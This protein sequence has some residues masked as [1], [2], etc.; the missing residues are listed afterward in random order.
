M[1]GVYSTF[2]VMDAIENASSRVM[3]IRMERIPL[4][5]PLLSED[6][7]ILGDKHFLI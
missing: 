7:R 2:G 1:V 6:K 4:S 5:K 3:T